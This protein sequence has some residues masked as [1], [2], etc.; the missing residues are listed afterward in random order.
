MIQSNLNID[1]EAL[2]QSYFGGG[3]LGR[4][5]KSAIKDGVEQV[6]KKASD[7]VKAFKLSKTPVKQKIKAQE[8]IS[9]QDALVGARDRVQYLIENDP[10]FVP[11][12]PSE[13]QGP[14]GTEILYGTRS[15]NPWQLAIGE[16]M[17]YRLSN[18][19]YNIDDLIPARRNG[20]M[21]VYRPSTYVKLQAREP[22][23]I[24]VSSDIPS[25]V[26]GYHS[27]NGKNVYKVTSNTNGP[28]L[29]STQIH[30]SL[31]HGTDDLLK[32]LGWVPSKPGEAI[33]GYDV[34]WIYQQWADNVSSLPIIASKNSNK[35]YE[36]RATL[37]ELRTQ[38]YKAMAKSK[39]KEFYK[40]ATITP[41][42]RSLFENNVDH[43]NAQDIASFLRNI[44]NY[45]NDYAEVLLREAESGETNKLDALK[46]LIKYAP[47]IYYGVSNM[48]TNYVEQR[49]ENLYKKGGQIHIK[50][51]NRGK[52]T[53]SAKAHGMGVQEY[54]HKVVNDPNATPLQRKRAQFALNSKKWSRH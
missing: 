24:V 34:P 43:M 31:M 15:A 22:I 51:K 46:S 19:G 53:A 28:D 44:N 48:P 33:T 18:F 42:F 23:D 39:G 49:S 17:I 54:A 32:A 29:Q 20:D 30:E 6:T 35:W 52:F 12:E 14:Y 27:S 37:G 8:G 40:Q 5:L 41:E 3:A 13:R 21:G 9:D 26:G 1:E 45:G 4:S 38:I 36:L 47:A 16:D 2:V 7:A 10:Y 50:E 25:N 11:Q